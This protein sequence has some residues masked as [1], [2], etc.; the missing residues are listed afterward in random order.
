MKKLLALAF[1][2]GLTAGAAAQT[3]PL[4]NIPMGKGPGKQGWTAV[5]PGA[6]GTCFIITAGVPNFGAC[7]SV[8]PSGAAGG[9]LTGTYPNPSLAAI[10]SATGPLGSAT[11]APIVTIDTKGRVTALTSATVTPA[12]GSV[13]GLGTGCATFLGTPSSANLR[14]CLTDE[15][16]TG[17][18]YFQGGD[19]GTPSAGVATN[20]TGINASN[21]S[22]GTL[23]N[24]RLGWNTTVLSGNPTNPTGTSS[25]SQVM[26]GLGVTTC[27]FT[28]SVSTRAAIRVTGNVANS[29]ATNNSGIQAR[30]GTGAAPANGAAASGTT[31][32]PLTLVTSPTANAIGSFT[33]GGIVT[34]LTAGVAIWIDVG[35]LAGANTTTLTAIM[36]VANE[37]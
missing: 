36:C 14:G 31:I 10:G 28:P 30:F 29:V 16:G 20:I 25:A 26:A 33:V 6:N 13:T 7:P 9:D 18:A 5:A 15:S 27:T 35:F 37:V 21:I 8:S 1:L 12:I 3:F 17:V 34:G 22:T 2:V 4:N 23:A 24:A 11:V 32:G 19:I